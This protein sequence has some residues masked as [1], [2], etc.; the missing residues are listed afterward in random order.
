[1]SG[2][3]GFRP[4]QVADPRVG[5]E[6]IEV[7]RWVTVLSHPLG[8]LLTI[9][10]IRDRQRGSLILGLESAPVPYGQGGGGVFLNRVV[11]DSR[12]DAVCVCIFTWGNLHSLDQIFDCMLGIPGVRGGDAVVG[13]VPHHFLKVGMLYKVDWFGVSLGE[14]R[15]HGLV[16]VSGGCVRLDR[17]QETGTA[18]ERGQH[19]QT[20]VD[21]YL[22]HGALSVSR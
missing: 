1:M 8:F 13:S 21:Q 6:L 16:G 11:L 5:S 12:F 19:P 7:L 22:A 9:L 18:D 14:S 20:S 2:R 17:C 15:I 3:N 4:S 10:V